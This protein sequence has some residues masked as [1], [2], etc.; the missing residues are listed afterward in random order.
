MANRFDKPHILPTKID[1]NK[2]ANLFSIASNMDTFEIKNI[3]LKDKI[4]LS[5]QDNNGNNLIHLTILDNNNNCELIRLEFIKFL[6]SENVNPDAPNRD[7]ITP[8]LYA[9]E[10]QYTTIVKY[11]IEI[12][13]D[14]NYA[15]NFNNNAY[16]YLFGSMIKNYR[17]IIQKSLFP[18]YKE[19][20]TKKI[21]FIKGIK[22]EIFEKILNPGNVIT[23]ELTSIIQTIEN[24][25]GTSVDAKNIVIEFQNEYNK[26]INST[27]TQQTFTKNELFS[28]MLNKFI[29]LIQ[30]KWN[31]FP[32][33]G[34]IEL[35]TSTQNSYPLGNES[36][37]SIIKNSDYKEYI[38]N[39]CDRIISNLN[40]DILK[41]NNIVRLI[42]LDEVN[43][44]LVTN[45]VA[46]IGRNLIIASLGGNEDE[47]ND[48]NRFIHSNCIDN[49]DNIIDYENNTFAGGSRQVEI[50]DEF[51]PAQITTL[52]GKGKEDIIGTLAYSLI[53]PYDT[54]LNNA[55]DFNNRFNLGG[56]NTIFDNIVKYI[57]SIA[58]NEK[59]IDSEE[60]LIKKLNNTDYIYLL[61]LI[62]KRENFKPGHY[63]YVFCCAYNG[64]DRIKYGDDNS[65]L[66]I[67]EDNYVP[68]FIIIVAK[69]SIYNVFKPL[70]ID[71]II[72]TENINSI[73]SNFI[74]LLLTD[75]SFNLFSTNIKLDKI[76]SLTKYFNRNPINFNEIDKE[77]LNL[78]EKDKMGMNDKKIRILHS[79]IL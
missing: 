58:M 38:K 36:G 13:V 7:N 79:S 45:F 3:S 64:I 10:R 53:K 51:T 47:Y 19:I 27:S 65:N 29:R 61:E 60:K 21:N 6:Y 14:I 16:H 22:K 56:G 33:S 54:G 40:D 71:N 31:Q 15:D 44:Q 39:E 77:Y 1:S 75:Q 11:L 32:K 78:T 46:S 23:P 28:T 34:N 67:E 37:L 66:K 25:V 8:L 57:Y 35:H 69:K 2:V 30:R 5:I 41:D 70:L 68:Q 50:I 48:M 18:R 17:P 76:E 26:L 49:A 63:L 59:I 9:C 52:F 55:F 24:S 43:N 42:D 72:T 74:K 20:D 12:G 73:Y 4:P 62:K